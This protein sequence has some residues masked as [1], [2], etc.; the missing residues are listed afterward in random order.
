MRDA[1]HSVDTLAAEACPG[2]A[3]REPGVDSPFEARC[4]WAAAGWK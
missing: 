1:P 2:A 3:S 4:Q